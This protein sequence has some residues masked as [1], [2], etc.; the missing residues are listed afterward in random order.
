MNTIAR[1]GLLSVAL[2]SR[3]PHCFHHSAGG[4]DIA[5]Y[6][7]HELLR[8][9]Y[10]TPRP[11]VLRAWQLL[12]T[13]L[14]FRARN[15]SRKMLDCYLLPKGGQRRLDIYIHDIHDVSLSALP[16]AYDDALTSVRRCCDQSSLCSVRSCPQTSRC[17]PWM[18][19]IR[20][21]SSLR[22]CL[23]EAGI[24]LTP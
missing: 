22:S 1:W 20:Q 14:P 21:T 16:Q 19:L 7:P 11:S 8:L 15:P 18:R 3:E 10:F 17:S 5:V 13:G 24:D 12:P 6:S 23:V 4:K 2:S 9:A